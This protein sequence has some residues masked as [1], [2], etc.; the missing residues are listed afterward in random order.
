MTL[1]VLWVLWNLLWIL[2]AM[3]WIVLSTMLE[4]KRK[5]MKTTATPTGF[6]LM[7][8]DHPLTMLIV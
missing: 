8:S 4:M 7:C 6:V 3:L 2:L 5:E 1:L